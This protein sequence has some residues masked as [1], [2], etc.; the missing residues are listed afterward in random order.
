MKRLLCIISNM[1]T[2]GA[3]TFLMKIYR[4]LDKNRYQMDFCINAKEKC[5]YEDE[6]TE[7]GGFIHRIPHKGANLK[8]FKTQLSA[9]VSKYEYEYVMR[10]TSTAMGFMDLKIAKKAGA[11]VCIARSSNASD[12]GGVKAFVAHRLGKIL[13]KKYVDVKIAPSDLAAS[14]TFGKKTYESGKVNILHNA[15]DLDVFHFDKCGRDIIRNEFGIN[16]STKVYGHIGRFMEQKNHKFLIEIFEKILIEEPNSVL[17]LVGNGTLEDLIRDQVARAGLSERVIFAGVRSDIPK[18]LSA[19]DVFVFPSLYEGMPNTVIEAQACGLPCII[20]DTIT[21]EAA[22]TDLVCYLPLE[23]N[24]LQWARMAISSAKDNREETK[25]IF[26][27]KK[28]D[29]DSTVRE[30]VSLVFE[31]K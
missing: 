19:M 17:M 21:K 3:E 11:S 24:A 2:G 27:A 31:S 4:R 6:I 1:N 30:F 5:F 22:I 12:G 14:Y 15:V 25:Q 23:D 28:Y 16:A 10:I 29:I 26:I 13:Y 8:E 7:M 20:A 18:V 9:I